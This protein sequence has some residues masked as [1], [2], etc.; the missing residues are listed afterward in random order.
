MS[1]GLTLQTS[2]TWSHAIDDAQQAGA[3][4]TVAYAQSNYLSGNYSADKG[5]SATDQRHRAVINWLWAPKLSKSNSWASRYLINGWELSSITTLA[6]SQPTTATVSLS[7]TQF[8]GVTMYASSINGTG[9][10]NRVPFW[11]VNS[12]DIDKMYRVDARLTRNLPFTEKVNGMLI[13]EA[14]NAF[15]TQYNTGVNT[16][17]YVAHE[18]YPRSRVRSRRW[19]PEPGLPGRHQRASRPGCLPRGL[20][21]FRNGTLREAAERCFAVS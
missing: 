12:L 3:S 14:F 20:L 4:T 8:T 10:W 5:S 19:Q 11:P 6:S 17:A 16:S 13:F 2:Y 9:G 15:N 21:D 1:H 18:G 7:G